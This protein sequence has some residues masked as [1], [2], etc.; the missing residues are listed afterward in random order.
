MSP[1]DCPLPPPSDTDAHVDFA[2][3]SASPRHDF[4]VNKER[5]HQDAPVKAGELQVWDVVNSTLMDHPFHLHGFFFQVLA[6]DGKPPAWHSWEDVVNL[7]RAAPPALPSCPTT[8]WAAGCITATS[9]TTRRDDGT[10]CA[11]RTCSDDNALHGHA[12]DRRRS[13]PPR[14]IA[15]IPVGNRVL[16]AVGVR[17]RR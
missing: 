11:L 2:S 6:V 4:V 5:H 9:H 13:F 3:S 1:D 17:R 8:A 16:T 15:E 7:R 14:F 12:R 10:G